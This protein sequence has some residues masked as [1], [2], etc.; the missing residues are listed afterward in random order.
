MLATGP[1]DIISEQALGMAGARPNG[2]CLNIW[3]IPFSIQYIQ[4]LIIMF[5]RNNSHF[6][7]I[8]YLQIFSDTPQSASEAEYKTMDTEMEPASLS[9]HALMASGSR[10][11][12]IEQQK[13][14]ICSLKGV[15]KTFTLDRRTH[16][17]VAGTT[18]CH[19]TKTRTLNWRPCSD[20][21]NHMKLWCW[22][23]LFLHGFLI[24]LIFFLFLEVAI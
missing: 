13:T 3:A 20:D 2:V 18:C 6:E 23:V 15:M 12:K 14:L 4:W 7:G 8:P 16:A 9:Y 19:F 11:V 17:T 24:F 21:R 22:G 1:S 5:L 10:T